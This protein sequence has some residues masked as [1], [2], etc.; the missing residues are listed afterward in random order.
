MFFHRHKGDL[1]EIERGAKR[2]MVLWEWWKT[3][4]IECV[5]NPHQE[6]RKEN[7]YKSERKCYLC[8][9]P[10]HLWVT[11]CTAKASREEGSIWMMKLIVP[12]SVILLAYTFFEHISP[13]IIN[14]YFSDQH[15]F[16]V[17]YICPDFIN[18]PFAATSSLQMGWF[19]F[20]FNDPFSPFSST[21][22]QSAPFLC[23]GRRPLLPQ[24]S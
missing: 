1:G 17:T 5:G 10:F 14:I 23:N 13:R 18:Y 12:L 6:K 9:S 15:A 11:S 22:T 2:A 7:V 21:V 20:V 3:G 24:Q 16:I 19:S 8:S 4:G